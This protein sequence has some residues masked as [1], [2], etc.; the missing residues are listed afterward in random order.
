MGKNDLPSEGQRF[1][2]PTLIWTL[3]FAYSEG[4]KQ[5]ESESDVWLSNLRIQKA[6]NSHCIKRWASNLC[7]HSLYVDSVSVVCRACSKSHLWKR[8]VYMVKID[9]ILSPIIVWHPSNKLRMNTSLLS[10]LFQPKPR[11]W[12]INCSLVVTIVYTK[13]IHTEMFLLN[14]N[15]IMRIETRCQ[16]MKFVS[17]LKSLNTY[18]LD[19]MF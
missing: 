14:T 18:I 8:F 7:L 12:K 9:H 6:G 10:L 19:S 11:E 16:M 4:K 13:L 1:T 3:T 2:T 15:L 5:S 17:G